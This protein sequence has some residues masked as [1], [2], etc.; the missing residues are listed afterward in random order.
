MSCWKSISSN[1]DSEDLSILYKQYII[2]IILEAKYT[3]KLYGENIWAK[4]VIVNKSFSFYTNWCTNSK[5]NGNICLWYLCFNHVIG[6]TD[7]WLLLLLQHL[8]FFRYTK[9]NCGLNI[10][11]CILVL[12]FVINL[13][14]M[15]VDELFILSK[16]I[17]PPYLNLSCHTILLDCDTGWSIRLVV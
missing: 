11:Y 5:F 9:F 10:L 15:L 12:L 8:D 14:K 13:H 17:D 6:P 1:T 4:N 7:L 16:F 2:L 3:N